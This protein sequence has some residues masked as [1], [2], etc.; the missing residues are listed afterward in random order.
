MHEN[1]SE[2]ALALAALTICENLIA[3][4]MDRGLL[5]AVDVEELLADAISVESEA[6]LEAGDV[7]REVMDG[8][9]EHRH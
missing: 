1:T 2:A 6:S 8:L 3:V 9:I 4:L 5:T 7:I